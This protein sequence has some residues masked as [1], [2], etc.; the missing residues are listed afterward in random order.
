MRGA[1]ALAWLLLAA[2]GGPAS[3]A[4]R[5][6]DGALHQPLERGP[7]T[8]HVVVFTSQEC[9]IANGYAP[10][11]K[12]LAASWIGKPVRLFLAHVDPDLTAEQARAH[13][14]AFDLPGTVLLDPH[15]DLARALGATRT[16]EAVVLGAA[17]I[18]YRGRIDDQWAAL[19][20]RAQEASVHDLRDAV[21]AVLAGRPVAVA[22]TDVVGC[23]LPEPKR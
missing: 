17:G 5:D 12:A 20:S 4:L 1:A 16:P 10:T 22:T 21:A 6:L 19:G 13:A 15:H 11:L 8:V 23:L 14:K 9:P 18:A 2:C 3:P 7:G